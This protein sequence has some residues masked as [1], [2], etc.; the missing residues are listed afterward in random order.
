MMYLDADNPTLLA[1]SS[2]H[3]LGG[4]SESPIPSDGDRLAQKDK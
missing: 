3:F 2:I 4:S 1:K